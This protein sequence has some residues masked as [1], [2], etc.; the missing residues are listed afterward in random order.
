MVRAVTDIDDLNAQLT[1]AGSKLVVI[2][3]YAVWCGPCKIIAPQIEEMEKQWG[4]EVSLNICV[5]CYTYQ[6]V[7]LPLCNPYTSSMSR[8]V[9]ELP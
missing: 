6:W 2:D 7:D 5:Q 4:E 8:Y 1:A 9:L 3:F